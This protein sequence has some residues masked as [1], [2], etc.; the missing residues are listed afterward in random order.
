VPQTNDSKED[1]T[2]SALNADLGQNDAPGG[3]DKLTCDDK[4]LNGAEIKNNEIDSKCETS[5]TSDKLH[6][7]DLMSKENK[8][9]NSSNENDIIQ[10]EIATK[11]DL[12]ESTVQNK[13]EDTKITLKK[14]DDE[15]GYDTY[16]K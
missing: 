14:S 9:D 11:K 5:A 10:E 8:E 1:S 15:K 16:S 3:N 12:D 7:E 2:D 4:N 13:N 6:V